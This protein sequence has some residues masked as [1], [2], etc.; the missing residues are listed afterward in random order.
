[1]NNFSIQIQNGTLIQD[2]VTVGDIQLEISRRKSPGKLTFSV[3]K[4]DLLNFT[5][6]NSVKLTLNGKGVFFGFVISKQRSNNDVIKVTAYDQIF[7]M[8]FK[9]TFSYSGKSSSDLIRQIANE[10][11]FNLGDIAETSY[12]MYGIEENKELIE[13]IQNSLDETTQ[14]TGKVYTMYD[15]FGKLTLKDVE[16]MKSNLYVDY[17]VITSFD[18][19]TSIEKNT[20]NRI[21]LA[22]EDQKK[23]VRDIYISEDSA[24]QNQF[25]ILQYFATIQKGENGKAK[26]DILLKLYNRR[27]R[28][29]SLNGVLGDISVRAGT[30]LPVN[31]NVGDLIIQNYMLVENVRHTFSDGKHLMDLQLSGGEFLA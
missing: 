24:S 7:Y 19:T 14:F 9:D 1:M 29:L 30:L 26:A 27:T 22:Y 16:D 6:G 11:G 25:G 8:K 5:E 13:I 20:Y 28:T 15:D 4:D 31:L 2:V 23:G 18:Y 17:E 21:K 3:V 10:R 12:T